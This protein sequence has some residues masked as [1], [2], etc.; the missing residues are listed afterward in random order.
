MVDESKNSQEGLRMR[1]PYSV[2]CSICGRILGRSYSGTATYMKCPKCKA[3]VFYTV[4]DN[5]PTVQITKGPK[6]PA[7]PA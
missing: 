7:I 6:H 1:T 3:E 4:N 2:H 5:G